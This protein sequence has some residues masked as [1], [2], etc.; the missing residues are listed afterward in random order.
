[1]W[2][3]RAV[4]GVA[5]TSISLARRSQRRWASEMM[6][7]AKA[8]LLAMLALSSSAYGEL[9]QG[10]N[11]LGEVIQIESNYDDSLGYR[12]AVIR[13]AAKFKCEVYDSNHECPLWD[14]ERECKKDGRS[15]LAG[16]KYK[17]VRNPNPLS[18]PSYLEKYICISGCNEKRVPLEIVKYPDAC[19]LTDHKVRSDTSWQLASD[20]VEVKDSPTACARRLYVLNRD[21]RVEIIRRRQECVNLEVSDGQF[22]EGQWVGVKFLRKGVVTTGWIFDAF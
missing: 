3:G 17:V 9:A 13:N 19:S 14:T 8:S 21:T 22:A 10:T 12:I 5:R 6:K 20:N 1:M 4:S 15:P 16:A 11:R 18:D 2:N 7:I